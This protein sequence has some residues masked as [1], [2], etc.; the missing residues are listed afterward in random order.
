M[1]RCMFLDNRDMMKILCMCVTCLNLF[2]ACPLQPELGTPTC[3]PSWQKKDV[4]R[5]DLKR[6]CGPSRLT[7]L[8]SCWGPTSTISSSHAPIGSY[9]T[10]SVYA[11]STPLRAP[12][13]GFCNL[14]S[15]V[16]LARDMDKGTTYLSQTHY[17][18]EFLRTYKF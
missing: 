1:E 13:R 18:K 4:Q 11:F 12:M 14:T 17:A 8:V 16:T 5:W 15:E 6:A 2:M 9:L 3:A 7:A 10:V